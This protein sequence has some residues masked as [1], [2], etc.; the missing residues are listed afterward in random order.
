MAIVTN[1]VVGSALA[2]RLSPAERMRMG[3]VASMMPLIPGALIV[4]ALV[5]RE[6]EDAVYEGGSEDEGGKTLS[7]SSIV[8]RQRLQLRS[9]KR[10]IERIEQGLRDLLDRAEAEGRS[11]SVDEWDWANTQLEE[12]KFL[13]EKL[14]E[15]T[16]SSFER[17]LRAHKPPDAPEDESE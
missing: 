13:E 10:A 1:F 15:E 2:S 7:A 6:P 12:L 16:T 8:E 14:A 5:E 11:L 9:D 3:V 17:A 4:Q